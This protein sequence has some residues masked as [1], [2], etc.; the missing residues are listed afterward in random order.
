MSFAIFAVIFS[1]VLG[2]NCRVM[3][4]LERI[5]Q[6]SHSLSP[7]QRGEL[8]DYLKQPNGKPI[9]AKKPVS[10]RGSWKIKTPE[11]FDLDATLREIRD[12]WKKE[13]DEL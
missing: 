9:A 5:K 12:E 8:A 7:K 11:N 2:Y 10:L 13:L 1:S 4:V 3:T 6:L